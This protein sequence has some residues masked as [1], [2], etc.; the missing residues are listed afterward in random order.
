[1]RKGRA[2]R[3]GRA[4]AKDLARHRPSPRAADRYDP[5]APQLARREQRIA[6]A[7]AFRTVLFL[8]VWIIVGGWAVKDLPVGILTAAAAAWISLK[9]MPSRGARLHYLAMVLL[10]LDFLRE[11]VV[12][13]VDVARR[14]FSPKLDIDPGYVVCPLRTPEGPARGA[15]LTMASLLPGTLPT[16]LDESGGLIV[17]AL[18]V[19]SPVADGLAHEEALFLRTI[20][21]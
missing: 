9:L 21:R 2:A 12:S 13:G 4:G 3:V 8:M 14:A 5:T 19:K 17:H 20:R 16:G 6:A 10:G 7:A 18:D 11:S 15:F 1:M